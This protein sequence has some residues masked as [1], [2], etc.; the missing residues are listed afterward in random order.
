MPIVFA[1]AGEV[2]ALRNILNNTAPQTLV[3]KLFTN[4]KIPAKTDVATDYIE[5]AGFG[6]SS[7]VLTPGNFVFTPGDPSTAVY[8][9]M[10][11]TFTGAAG[12]IYGYFV[13]QGNSGSLLFANRFLN[14]P[15]QIANSG[16]EIRV[17]LTITLNNP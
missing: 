17:T 10:T 7:V 8:P 15:I 14:S 16:D 2:I 12:F 1:N 13:I 11:F 4:N 6:Y 9:Q 5:L 3:L